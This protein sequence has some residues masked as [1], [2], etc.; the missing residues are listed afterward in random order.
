[1]S[2]FVR[3]I[4]LATLTLG[5][6]LACVPSPRAALPY[7]VTLRNFFGS[8][9]FPRSVQFVPYPD[10]DSAYVIV[11]QAGKLMTV[12]RT[13]GNWARTDSAV[14]PV[15]NGNASGSEQGLLGMT[16]HP[17]WRQNRKYY[18]YHVSSGAANGYNHIAERTMDSTL[19]PHTGDA[20]RTVLKLLDPYNNHNSGTLRFGADGYLYFA[21]GDGGSANDPQVRAQNLDSLFGKF[22]RLDVN[23][24]DAY[25]ADTTKN[26]AIP[27][28]N[29]FVNQGTKRPEI[30]AYGLRNPFR[31]TFHP[32][33]GE[34]W[35][36]D[37]GQDNVEEISHVTKGANMGWKIME[38]NTCFNPSSTRSPLATCANTGMTIPVI[39][40]AR[41][42]AQSITGG[43]FFTGNPASVF[44]GVYF[45][46]DYASDSLWAARIV[47]DTVTERIR[48]GS[49]N[50]V[51]SFN[52]DLQGRVFAVSV[53]NGTV[54]LL[55]SP[56]MAPVAAS[57][58]SQRGASGPIFSMTDV[59]R[60]PDDYEVRALDGRLLSL[61]RS[62]FKGAVWVRKKSSNE[63]ARLLSLIA[64]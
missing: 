16:F 20:Q 17:N 37:V 56:D 43:D 58:R 30:W 27:A 61:N 21:L 22:W 47:N 49:L 42:A 5:L 50:A 25:P 44:H 55:E 6:G 7:S 62:G 46:G 26:Y 38:G 53:D 52:R 63:T 19:R 64:P 41:S 8:M 24:T 10:E 4:T 40:V 14:I 1:M 12:R 39:S 2:P 13:G 35:V 11:Q 48:I 23:G 9:T 51:A 3:K 57:L 59:R 29:P 36:G 33:T 28:D 34:I 54:N 60:R 18:I 32:T 45:Y 31:W 15:L